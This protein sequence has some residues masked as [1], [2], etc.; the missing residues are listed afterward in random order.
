MLSNS[1]VIVLCSIFYVASILFFLEGENVTI[2][3]CD[4]SVLLNRY[5]CKVQVHSQC[6]YRN[7]GIVVSRTILVLSKH[8]F[9]QFEKDI[10][11]TRCDNILFVFIY[12]TPSLATPFPYPPSQLPRPSLPGDFPFTKDLIASSISDSDS[13]FFKTS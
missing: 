1:L 12:C 4:L 13:G 10:A 3:L 2:Y 9:L 5:L 11:K 7:V 6:I 8:G